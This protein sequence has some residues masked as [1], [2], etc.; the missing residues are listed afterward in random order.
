MTKGKCRHGEFELEEGCK[1]CMAEYAKVNSAEN[2]RKRIEEA[3]AAVKNI[4]IPAIIV[5]VRYYSE[6]TGEVSG[7][8]Y[9][10]FTEE[11]LKVGDIVIVP[12]RDTTGK[13]RVSAINVSANEIAKFRDKV[14]MIPAG[15]RVPKP[16]VRPEQV[17]LEEGLNSE[18]F[19]LGR[20]Y[21]ESV[22]ITE[23]LLEETAET[24]LAL[25]P[26]EDI[27]AH[28]HFEEAMRILELAESFKIRTV[29]DVGLVTNDLA[30]LAKLRKAMDGKRKELLKPLEEQKVAIRDT[31]T[32]LMT[33]VL[34]AD[35]IYRAKIL[36]YDAE[37]RRLRFEQEEINRLRIEAAQK[38]MELKGELTEDI[39][40]VEVAPEAP[41]RVSTDMGSTSQ[42]MIRKW[43]LVDM[44]QVPEDYKILDS[45]RISKVVKAGIPSIPGIRIYEEPI[46]TVRG[47]MKNP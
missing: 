34:E 35:R 15:S 4:Q 13:A 38:E 24:A 9:T 43:E 33:P 18:G 41:R 28:R 32:Y 7:R 3:A 45:A 20:D 37:Q 11:S 39:K 44:A 30:I 26:G 47:S 42:R 27:E 16:K 36:T 6:T 17:E 5:K 1:A 31:Y 22:V 2:I 19:T 29:E 10:Y 46:I 14:K 21:G 40:L 12:V 8:E 25:R 23:S